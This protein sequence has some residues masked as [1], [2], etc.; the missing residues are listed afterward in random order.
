MKKFIY[1]VVL[2]VIA[3]PLAWFL[4]SQ[5]EGQAPQV[6]IKLPSL[7]LNKSYEM[8]INAMDAG[9]GLRD[10]KVSLMQQGK[11]K[12]LLD[13]HYPCVG[14]QRFFMGSQVFAEP[15]TIPVEAWKYAMTDG[16]AVF[17]I[18]VSDYSWRGWN[19]GNTIYQ[20]HKV[21]ID[22][23][24]PDIEVLTRTHNITRGGSGLVIYKAFETGIRSGVQVGTDFFP[25]YSGMFKDPS[26]YAAFFALSYL[27]G[28][29][30][31]ISVIAEDQAGNKT[32]KGF[33]HYIKDK[34]FKNDTLNISDHFL[35]RKMPEFDLGVIEDTFKAGQ[36]PLLEKFI[37]INREVRTSNI[38]TLLA[39]GK[40]TS[41]ELMWKGAFLR[42]PKSANRAGFADHRIYKYK[43]KEID[44]QVHLGIDLAS[45]AMAPVPAANSGIVIATENIG[46]FG[47]TVVIDHGF[48]LHSIYSHLSRI[49]VEKGKA[50]A[51]GDIIG[52]SGATGLAGGDHLHLGMTV[53]SVFVNPLEWWDMSWID[54]NIVSKINDVQTNLN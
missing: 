3:L 9:T 6:T 25:G 35:E 20:E 53:Q 26:I 41:P 54:N 38:A 19:K 45:V 16:D 42:L 52:T 36:N 12:I 40:E 18:Y 22:T 21:V 5:F 2:L 33:Y 17:R 27:Q 43:G 29:G 7:Y 44:R 34:K 30:T 37:H 39:A 51:R 10:V 8:S 47:N 14:Y 13:K 46:I 48:G 50:V 32:T 28:L 49:A 24:S 15:F 4:F 31:D 23:K 1:I 11:E